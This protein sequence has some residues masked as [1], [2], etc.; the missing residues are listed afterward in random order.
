M[1]L[2]LRRIWRREILYLAL[3]TMEVCWFW[4]WL[5]LLLSQATFASW[6]S[7]AGLLLFATY[8]TRFMHTRAIKLG[9]QRAVTAIIAIPTSLLLL[10]T[11]V[12]ADLAWSDWTWLGAF[13]WE[14]S[15]VMQHISAPLLVFAAALYLWFRG[16]SLAQRDI[17]VDS[18]GFS[19]RVGIAA[20]VWLFLVQIT[21]PA[22]RYPTLVLLYFMLGLLAVGLARIEGV[23][24]SR[25]GVRSPFNAS[26]MAI[27]LGS[28]AAL[29]ATCVGVAWIFSW[30]NLSRVVQLLRP[31]WTALG[32]L[33]SPIATVLAW[34]LQQM[35]DLLIRLFSG[36]FSYLGGEQGLVP[37]AGVRLEQFQQT[38]QAGG[39]VLFVLQVLKWGL[40]A[41]VLAL[42]LVIIALSVDRLRHA[43]GDEGASQQATWESRRSQSPASENTHGWQRLWDGLQ[44]QLARLFGDDYSLVSVRRI[45]AS[46]QRLAAS[47]GYPRS[48][49]ATPYEYMA[50]LTRGFQGSEREIRL[51]T[52]AYVRTH[53]GQRSFPPE[54][55]QEVRDAWLAVRARQ[56][57]GA[58]S[59]ATE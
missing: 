11:V 13:G 50:T 35:L 55:V 15:N 52:E 43:G 38:Q 42:V 31:L 23:S 2:L 34:L 27:L 5:A 20:F 36:L 51:I 4:S 14:L 1:M 7:C 58:E 22:V 53:Y 40:L 19:F 48:D 21:V 44:E 57:Q 41:F 33:T 16:I 49:A 24:Q 37:E 54:Y 17:G 10:R 6:L 45:Y 25:I 32:R 46:L 39:I 12:Y 30:Q 56:E 28:V 29:L 26:W 8:L 47:S 3:A 18:V 9:L 59:A